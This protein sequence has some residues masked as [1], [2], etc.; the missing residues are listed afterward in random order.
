MPYRT[1]DPTR[2]SRQSVEHIF[3]HAGQPVTW[4]QYISASAGNPAAGIS[5]APQFREQAITALFGRIDTQ[6][7]QTPA[8]LLPVTD[9]YAVTREPVSS[10][11]EIIW[12]GATYHVAG[13]P[14]PS[15]L[16]ATW[17]SWLKRGQ[18]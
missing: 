6:N 9:L 17:V 2:L 13:H 3:R 5:D 14:A 15:P 11:D 7:R 1:P 4:R 16:G 8:G 18:E 10:R 12:D